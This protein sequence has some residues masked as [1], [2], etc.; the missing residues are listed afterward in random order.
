MPLDGRELTYWHDLS[1]AVR[2][3]TGRE[4]EI[5]WEREGELFTSRLTPQRTVDD[6]TG[7]V[8]GR[9]GITSDPSDLPFEHLQLGLGGSLSFAG[10]QTWQTGTLIVDILARL[11]SGQLSMRETLGGPVTIARV[12]R[13]SA[14]SGLLSLLAFVAFVSVNLGVLNLLPIPVLDG[15]HLV[16]LAAEAL[17]GKPL[18]LRVRLIATQVGMAF[19]I[20][21]M[22]YVTIN[23]VVRLF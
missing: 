18:S 22:L 7:E 2:A 13:D 6:S 10:E 15:G 9:I 3:S 4:V 16:F 11:I 19:I 20:L 5:T 21:I 14:R 12:A 23:D 8:R 1:E 17:R